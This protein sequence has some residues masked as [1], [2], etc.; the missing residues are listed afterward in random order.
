MQ[1]LRVLIDGP[2][3]N[4]LN[5]SAIKCLSPHR[6]ISPAMCS[7]Y[8]TE[9]IQSGHHK[10]Y[11]IEHNIPYTTSTNYINNNSGTV[12]LDNSTTTMMGVDNSVLQSFQTL[13]NDIFFNY[14]DHDL[15]MNS[16]T[17]R[18]QQSMRPTNEAIQ[19]GHHK[20]YCTEHNT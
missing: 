8:I 4:S 6:K 9:A 14:N 2:L 19:S 7:T 20:K 11:H 12:S 13:I 15:M 17:T 18:I 10:Q 3:I 16:D 5:M 1:Q